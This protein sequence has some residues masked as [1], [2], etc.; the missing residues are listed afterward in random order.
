[1]LA[2][3]TR[4]FGPLFPLSDDLDRLFSRF[5]NGEF[6]PLLPEPQDGVA[7]LPAIDVSSS[8]KEIVVRAEVPGVNPE[9]IEVTVTGRV[10]T[11]AGEKQA[12]SEEN[13][14]DVHYGER[15]FGSFRRVVKLPTVVDTESITASHK[16]G[17]LEIRLSKSQSVLPKRIP[18]QVKKN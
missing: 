2:L 6:E 10:L 13:E 16:D 5:G 4:T 14:E 3:R 9:N 7:W 18:V 15:R 12:A 17:V 8:E 1:M 11:I